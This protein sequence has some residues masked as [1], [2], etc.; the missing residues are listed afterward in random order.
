MKKTGLIISLFAVILLLSDCSKISNKEKNDAKNIFN[1]C[2]KIAELW[3]NE[4]DEN[5]YSH[6]NKLKLADLLKKEVSE[7]ELR[8]YISNN[9]RIFGRVNKR[10]FIGAHFWLNKKL[11]SYFPLLDKTLLKRIGKTEARD[12]FYRVNPR[13]MGLKRS[14]DMF[15]SFPEGNYVIMMYKSIPTNKQTAGEKVI[16]WKDNAGIWQVV[17]YII[18]DDI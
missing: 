10:E 4:L 12:G 6:L 5:G 9:E 7:D 17:S 3:L 2:S 18:A 11:I 15:R 13:Y 8:S 1:D 16:L 14:A